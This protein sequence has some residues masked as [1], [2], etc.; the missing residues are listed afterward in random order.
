MRVVMVSKA[1]IVGQYQKKLEELAKYPD[2]E[3]TVVVPP[4]W[5]DERGTIR[6]ERVYTDGYN[7]LVEPMRFNGQ[8]HLHYYPTLPEVFKNVRPHLV[9][10]DEEPYNFATFLALR[11]AKRA[12]AKALFF[13]WQNILRQYPP[14]F[15]WMERYVFRHSDYAI[16][17]NVES[18]SILH[19]KNFPGPMRVIPQFGVDPSLF[20]PKSPDNCGKFQIGFAGGRLVEEKGIDLLL[21]AAERLKGDWQ[22]RILGDGPAKPKLEFLARSLGISSRVQFDAPRLSAEMPPYYAQL[23][24]LVLP[25]RT[26]SNWKE[27][28]GRVLIEAMACGI[29]VIGS[30]SGEIPNVIGDAGLIFH[31]EDIDALCKHLTNLLDNPSFRQELGRRGRNRVLANYTQARVAEETYQV[32]ASL[33]N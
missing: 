12:G 19:I 7:L 32:Y 28:F 6:L 14:P 9:H 1:C 15:S 24:A 11:S 22:V 33:V 10:I 29:P 16:A 5:R 30:D 18:G 8:F 3:L 17:G 27:Q 31:E 26:R 23:D 21:R 13:T 20:S 4:L 25:S 2:L